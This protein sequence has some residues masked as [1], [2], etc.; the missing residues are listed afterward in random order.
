MVLIML[1]LNQYTMC[2]NQRKEPFR[3][4]KKYFPPLSNH[5]SNQAYDNYNE[6]LENLKN[7]LGIDHDKYREI[8]NREEQVKKTI[9]STYSGDMI[10]TTTNPMNTVPLGSKLYPYTYL[11]PENW[12]RA[13]EQPPVCIVD[14]PATVSPLTDPT[15]HGLI[16]FDTMN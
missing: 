9:R 12:F 10:H 15:V 13:Y 8:K 2:P 5:Q 11:P 6:D 16:E 4:I 14:K 3:K 1:L 7:W